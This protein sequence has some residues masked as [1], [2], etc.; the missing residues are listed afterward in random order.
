MKY[1]QE[2]ILLSPSGYCMPF[3]E[4]DKE[5]EMTLGYGKQTDPRTGVEFFHHGVNFSAPHYLLAAVASGTVC[6][7]GTDNDRGTYQV[8]RYGDYEVIYG[9]LSNILAGYGEEVRAGQTVGVSDE[10]LHMETR[11]KGEEIDPIEFLT[12]IYGNIRNME[13]KGKTFGSYDESTLPFEGEFR[14]KYDKHAD[15]IEELLLRLFPAYLRDLESGAYT[16]PK[17]VEN[18]LRNMLLMA[19]ARNY[20]FE[21]MPSMENPMG[22]GRKS[23]PLAAKV[24]NLMIEDFLNYLA[25]VMGVF[26]SWWD[27]DVKKKRGT[28]P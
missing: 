1:T 3:E 17:R 18:G 19:S 16:L 25:A 10:I 15:E 6:G 4:R 22:L 24:Q 23:L 28:R 7:I 12:M 14:T 21:V 20:F 8:I 27:E 11:F 9:H 5:V 26:P 13:R 2:M